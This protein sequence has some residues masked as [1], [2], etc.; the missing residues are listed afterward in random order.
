MV[1]AQIMKDIEIVRIEIYGIPTPLQRI[2]I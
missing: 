2:D 1:S